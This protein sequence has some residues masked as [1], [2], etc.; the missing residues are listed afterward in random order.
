[1]I[2]HIVLFGLLLLASYELT[3]L[4]KIENKFK[5][6]IKIEGNGVTFVEDTH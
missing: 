6:K 4:I 1:M 5:I 3:A 2:Y